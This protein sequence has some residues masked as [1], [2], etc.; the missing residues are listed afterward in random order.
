MRARDLPKATPGGEGQQGTHWPSRREELQWGRG[1]NAHGRVKAGGKS[2]T[3]QPSGDIRNEL[4]EGTLPWPQSTDDYST[5]SASPGRAA[6]S[7][8][9][10]GPAVPTLP[11][12]CPSVV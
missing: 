5:P 12:A 3:M 6:S 9:T 7:P 8:R 4:A 1:S 11:L 10:C 2:L